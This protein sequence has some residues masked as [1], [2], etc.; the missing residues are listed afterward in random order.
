MS[1]P[2]A[3]TVES[4]F[5]YGSVFFTTVATAIGNLHQFARYQVASDTKAGMHGLAD[6]FTR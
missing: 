5:L 1:C 4:D 3:E 6:R 2:T